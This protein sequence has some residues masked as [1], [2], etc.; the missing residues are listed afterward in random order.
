MNT[1]L[2]LGLVL[3]GLTSLL[4]TLPAHADSAGIDALLR[5]QQTADQQTSYRILATYTEASG[6]TFTRTIE[7]VKPD[8]YHLLAGDSRGGGEVIVIGKNSYVRE[9]T[10]AWQKSKVDLT[11][12][13][14]GGRLTKEALASS[15]ISL[16]GSSSL[17][18]VPMTVYSMT[19]AKNTMKSTGKIWISTADNLLRHE[20]S[21]IELPVTKVGGKSFGGTTHSVTNWEYNL[22]L[23]IKAPI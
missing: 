23:E 12:Q 5:S 18:G 22:K 21:A 3:L 10:G 6:T 15:T 17:A 4:F 19:Y 20:E 16:I 13:A 2:A 1:R 8:R 9:G 11:A 14:G 7:F